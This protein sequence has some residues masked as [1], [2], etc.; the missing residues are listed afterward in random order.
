MYQGPLPLTSLRRLTVKQPR[1]DH[2]KLGAQGGDVLVSRLESLPMRRVPRDM[3]ESCRLKE[4]AH[5]AVKTKPPLNE[6]NRMEG[7]LW[8][9]LGRSWTEVQS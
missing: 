5:S 6:R 9:M 8:K 1:V 4:K 3:V 2:L 7:T